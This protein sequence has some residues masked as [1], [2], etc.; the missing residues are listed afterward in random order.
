[1]KIRSFGLA[2]LCAIGLL[3]GDFAGVRVARA[4]QCTAGCFN[5]DGDPWGAESSH[6]CAGLQN[7]CSCGVDKCG[8][9]TS[10]SGYCRQDQCKVCKRTGKAGGVSTCY[11]DSTSCQS[12]QPQFQP[13]QNLS[14]C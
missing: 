1:M 12:P 13:C 3:L 8:N 6:S 11:Q 7:N 10:I 14:G 4:L 9:P 5:L 2:L